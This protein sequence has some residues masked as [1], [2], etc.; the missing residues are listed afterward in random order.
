M[1]KSSDTE[2]GPQWKDQKDTYQVKHNLQLFCKFV[3][4]V[5]G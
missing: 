1:W 4:L 5:L 2:F 3:A